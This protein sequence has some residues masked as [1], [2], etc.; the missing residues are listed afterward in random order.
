[1]APVSDWDEEGSG[2]VAWRCVAAAGWN[3]IN[4]ALAVVL[5]RLAAMPAAAGA[6]VRLL[7]SGMPAGCCWGFWC[8]TG[9]RVGGYTGFLWDAGRAPSQDSVHRVQG[10]S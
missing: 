7:D 8:R 6:G 10:G 9:I 1:M 4:G 3:V 5:L 2:A